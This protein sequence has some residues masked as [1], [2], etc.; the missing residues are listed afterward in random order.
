MDEWI[1]MKWNGRTQF[2]GKNWRTAAPCEIARE[3]AAAV[4]IDSS[5]YVIGGYN[6]S[7][8][9]G[10][11]VGRGLL[12]SMER[13]DCNLGTWH[14]CESMSL[15]RRSH[16][17]VAIPPVYH[18]DGTTINKDHPHAYGSILVIGGTIDDGECTRSVERYC[19][20]QKKWFDEPE[21]SL[22][23]ALYNFTAQ[24]VAGV[25]VTCGGMR[26]S[27]VATP[28]CFVLK[29]PPPLPLLP[30]SGSSDDFR[31]RATFTNGWRFLS[32]LP[33]AVAGAASVV[34]TPNR[35]VAQ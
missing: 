30:P 3:G 25:V 8:Y 22:P 5:I 6:A 21:L 16:A 2:D 9:K 10:L 14:Q 27:F 4:A 33:H 26:S 12:T 23:L 11:E 20:R 24:Y 17:A 18:D 19:F 34:L 28:D 35:P 32:S 15:A 1:W 29:Y 7:V 13:F 31:R